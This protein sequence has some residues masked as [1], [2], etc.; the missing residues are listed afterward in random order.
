MYP[1]VGLEQRRRTRKN[2][3]QKSG[4][5]STVGQPLGDDEVAMLEKVYWGAM[6][7]EKGEGSEDRRE[8]ERGR[9]GRRKGEERRGETE[10]HRESRPRQRNH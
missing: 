2:G 10:R 3:K 6:P 7:V 5:H 9:K 8:G 4:A 1:R